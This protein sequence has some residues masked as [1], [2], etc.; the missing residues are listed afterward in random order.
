MDLAEPREGFFAL[1]GRQ[2]IEGK[3]RSC[4][5]DLLTIAY[6]LGGT[7]LSYQVTKYNTL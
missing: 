5:V 3:S 4:L 2:D 1:V 6:P 7:I